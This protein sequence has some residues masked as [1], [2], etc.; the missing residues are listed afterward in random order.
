MQSMPACRAEYAAHPVPDLAALPFRASM[1]KRRTFVTSL[2]AAAAVTAGRRSAA[3][4]TAH[5]EHA[6]VIVVGAGLAGLNAALVLT[7]VGATVRV[8]ESGTRVG[9]R[10]WTAEDLPGR[11][12]LGASQVFSMYARVRALCETLGVALEL[13]PAGASAESRRAPIALSVN[14][15]PVMREPWESAASNR[16]IGAER[17]IS[18]ALLYSYYA[19]KCMTFTGPNDWLSTSNLSLDDISIDRL[20][21]QAG[22]SDQ[23]LEYMNVGSAPRT[24]SDGSALDL[25]HKNFLY[26]WNGEQGPYHHV[27]GGTSALPLAMAARLGDSV[28]LRHRVASIVADRRGVDIRCDNGARFRASACVCAVP[29]SVLRG[30]HLDA[31]LSAAQRAAI[32]TMAYT[33]LIMGFLSPRRR[34]W[35]DDGLPPALWTNGAMQ[36]VLYA[37][38]HVD[39][40]G[41]LIVYVRGAGAQAIRRMG[42]TAAKAFFVEELARLRPASRGNVEF[43]RY[44][45]WGRHP[46][47]RG[48][49]M[50]YRPGEV[51][52]FREHVGT[53]AGRVY[54]AGEH[55]GQIDPGMEGACE[56]GERAAVAIAAQG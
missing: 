45:D 35:E 16:L 6:D 32:D 36:Q 4:S 28:R 47:S 26:R 53:P 22:A 48:A 11:P 7:S 24:L 2:V 54:F 3:Q 15:S 14:G 43:A 49:Y 50:Y 55:I 18:P 9:G 5:E 52:R 51:R 21:R 19:A 56:S 40:I 27:R 17:A 29:F 25:Q 13:P 1:M 23:A 30:V 37:P 34:F 33:D 41:N 42:P 38:S 39:E 31:P 44:L 8:L 12:E 10:C 20:F 46:A